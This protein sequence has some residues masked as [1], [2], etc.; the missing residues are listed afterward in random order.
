[1]QCFSTHFLC[2]LFL[3]KPEITRIFA[4][5]HE[6]DM[7]SFNIMEGDNIN[8][9]C[10][11]ALR[12]AFKS[13]N[14][15][16]RWFRISDSGIDE[17]LDN[18]VN[19]SETETEK[20]DYVLKRSSIQLSNVKYH[21]KGTYGCEV[22]NGQAKS[23][24]NVLVRVKDKMAALWPFL[25]IVAEVIVL[26]TVICVYEKRRNKPE[27]EELDTNDSKGGSSKTAR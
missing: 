26:C 17:S 1:M 12:P 27:A 9:V 23:A 2:L 5:E 22:V 25:G 8:L 13:D 4:Q 6:K 20:K 24:Y 21:D 7:N 11:V 10:E 19:I 16:F 14:L 3:G 18:L 15:E